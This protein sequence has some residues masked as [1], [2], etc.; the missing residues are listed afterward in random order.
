MENKIYVV[1]GT[2]AQLIKMAPIMALMQNEGL[3]YEFIYTAQHRE[4]IDG[5]LEDFCVKQPDRII[6]DKAEANTILKFAGWGGEML[7]KI[8]SA[9]KIFP[10]K[11]IVLTHGDTATCTWAAVTGKLAGCK[12]AHVESGLRSFNIFKP[13]PEEIMR[14]ITFSFSDV[15][16]C[17]NEWALNNLKK[18]RGDKVNLGMNPLYDAVVAALKSKVEVNAPKE[19]YVVVSIHRYENI[20]NSRLEKVIIPILEEIAEKGFKLVFVLHPSTREVLKKDGGALYNRLDKNKNILLNQR[21]PFFKFIKL[22]NDSEFVITDGGSN[23]E[24]LSYL[25]K[26]TLLFRE[27]TERI[28]GLDQNIVISNFDQEVVNNFLLNYRSLQLPFH[29]I[30]ARPSQKVIDYLLNYIK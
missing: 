2:R 9:K 14:L 4:T 6:Y 13:F 17:P 12:I 16:F 22:L 25:G 27:V 7:F 26:P 15:Y 19:K 30:S 8:L 5:I 11:G 10:Q 3:D 1:I 23:Q 20:F 28:E 21:Y 18:Y 29:E 24:E